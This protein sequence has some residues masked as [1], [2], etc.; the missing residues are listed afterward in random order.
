MATFM[1]ESVSWIGGS[2]LR[3]RKTTSR[4]WC[5][6]LCCPSTYELGQCLT[7]FWLDASAM[8]GSRTLMPFWGWQPTNFLLIISLTLFGQPD[9]IHCNSRSRQKWQIQK[10]V[11][12]C[13]NFVE[14]RFLRAKKKI[15]A[16]SFLTFMAYFKIKLDTSRSTWCGS[17]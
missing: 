7:L 2:L 3:R 6:L 8:H 9:F 13:K 11:W 17:N 5:C 12:F 1:N 15:K 10:R 14:I 4:W 16:S